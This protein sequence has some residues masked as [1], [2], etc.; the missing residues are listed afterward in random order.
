MIT[1]QFSLE[2]MPGYPLEREF[3]INDI[4]FF[5]IETTGLSAETSYLYL[6]GC[7]YYDN[8]SFQILQWFSE[9]IKEEVLLLTSFFEFAKNYSVLIHYNGSGFDIPYLQHKCALHHLEYSFDHLSGIDLYK[10]I[11]PYKKILH[12]DSLKLASLEAFLKI[13]RRDKFSGGELIQVYQAYLGKKHYEKLKKLRN[14]GI[15]FPAPSEAELLLGQLLLHNEDDIRGLLEICPILNYARLFEKPIRIKEACVEKDLLK[16][17]FDISVSLPVPVQFGND[18]VR[19]AAADRAGTLSVRIFE[20][21]L[22][23]F[24]ENY[25]DYYYLPAEDT[26]VHK[27]L[28]Q[29]V[30]KEFRE[31]AKPA[32]CYI[33]KQGHFAPQYEA[34]ISPCFKMD[35]KDKRSY[36]EIHT[37]FLLQEDTLERYVK[38]LLSSCL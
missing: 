24:Y 1:R 37:D 33:R 14:P 21:E 38:H 2:Q 7:A 26:A 3:N 35:F 19:V 36:I 10:K 4:L 27:S 17:A 11:L 23:H 28:A 32:N 16:V 18:L 9:D 34:M 25:K 6:I 29:Y 8:S 30:D 5:D 15:S 31:K 22:K 13:R 12:L 20:G